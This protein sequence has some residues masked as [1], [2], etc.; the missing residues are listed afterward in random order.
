[1][2]HKLIRMRVGDYDEAREYE[3][4]LDSWTAQGYKV[5]SCGAT[6]YCTYAWAVLQKEDARY[7]DAQG[8]HV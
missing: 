4:V 6:D 3:R 1:M 7:D 8:H 2:K 5:I